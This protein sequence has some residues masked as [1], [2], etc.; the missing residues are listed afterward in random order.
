[1][2]TLITDP[3]PVGRVLVAAGGIVLEQVADWLPGGPPSGLVPV[4]GQQPLPLETAEDPAPGDSQHRPAAP[5]RRLGRAG[6]EASAT[7]VAGLILECLSGLRPLTHLRLMCTEEALERV[8]RWPRGPGWRNAGVTGVP[9]TR[10]AEGRVDA[11]VMVEMTGHRLAMALCLRRR[12]G[13]WLVDDAQLLVT[14]GLAE[15]VAVSG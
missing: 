14:K 2:N 8:K 3:E 15:L 10:L 13:K 12:T 9:Q 7:A 6:A 1:M 11:V 5:P 4:I